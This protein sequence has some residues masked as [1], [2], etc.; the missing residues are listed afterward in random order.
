MSSLGSKHI[1]VA[2]QIR[3]KSETILLLLKDYT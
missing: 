2:K 1:F 3:E